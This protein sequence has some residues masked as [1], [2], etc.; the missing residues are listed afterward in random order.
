MKPGTCMCQG[1]GMSHKAPHDFSASRAETECLTE[2]YR[3]IGPEKVIVDD[4]SLDP[5]TESGS[6]DL[7]GFQLSS[8]GRLLD[9]LPL[10]ALLVSSDHKIAFANDLSAR[11]AGENR[12]VVGSH[13]SSLFPRIPEAAR[14]EELLKTVFKGRKLRMGE[15]AVELGAMRLW[16]RM[17][18]RPIRIAS[19]RFVLVLVEDLSLEKKHLLLIERHKELIAQAK[20]SFEKELR[21][22]TNELRHAYER[23]EQEMAERANV[24]QSLHLSE[25][26]FRS[27]VDRTRDGILVVDLADI[28]LYANQAAARMFGRKLD[29]L[30]EE[31]FA[32]PLSPGQAI[33]LEIMRHNGEDGV[34]EARVERTEWN[35]KPAYLVVIRDITDMKLSEKQLM[36]AQKLESLELIAGG[37]AHDFN[38]LLTANVANISLAKMRATPGTPI[39]EALTKAEKAA[40][41]AR[42]LT[43]QLLTFTKGRVPVKRPTLLPP[44]I[45][46]CLSL[47]MGGSNVKCELR[48]P[49]DLWPVEA[50]PSQ[51]AML[52]QN[53]MIN[54]CQAMPDGG[55]I[56]IEGENVMAGHPTGAK[57]L[58][59]TQ[60]RFAR[61]S[62][63]D[64][65]TG[66]APD[67]LAK[68]FE[69][70][71][72][73]KP[74]GSGLGLATAHSVVQNHGG[75]IEV[76]SVAGKGTCFYVYLPATEKD[77]D[78][79]DR[80]SEPLPIAGTGRILIMDDEEDIR[81]AAASVL[82]LLG[83]H[84]ECTPNGL[85]T[86]E[87][88]KAASA[89]GNR[90]DAVIVDLTIPGGMGGTVVAE[91]LLQIDRD[92]KIILSTGHGS[93]P[94]VANYRQ[95]G[96]KGFVRKPYTAVEIGLAVHN[97]LADG[98]K[99]DNPQNH[100]SHGQRAGDAP[101]KAVE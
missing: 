8:V 75:R 14:A 20:D 41:K 7:R 64:T 43:Q 76:K 1:Y 99:K 36:R 2:L 78:V 27:I 9:A 67:H 12:L 86:L 81:E 26:G 35:G 80:A 100:D 48:I 46:E 83:Y 69:P 66:I 49:K 94:I 68:I 52:F 16:A 73:T 45:K 40:S 13:F 11:L 85:E 25:E 22:R 17:N 101:Q 70:Y 98:V 44:L 30:L 54:A 77:S 88:Y 33:E 58:A 93:D 57:Q 60:S 18:F 37:V 87:K 91:K 96:F 89:A 72:T 51:V 10:I 31:R 21:Q 62:F 19:T 15:G 38:N 92:A 71:F 39:Y 59:P 3:G 56:I 6:F 55:D 74:K 50:E 24:Q 32:I 84:V 65:G 95:Y 23:L 82:E 63:Q 5:F 29:S 4:R 53:L 28:V 97:V 90:F 47:A 42:D 34:A 61:I 79:S